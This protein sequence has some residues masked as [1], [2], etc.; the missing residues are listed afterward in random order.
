MREAV[1][2]GVA[3]DGGH[4][5]TGCEASCCA[6]AFADPARGHHIACIGLRS[7]TRG[8][9]L[10]ATPDIKWQLHGLGRPCAGIVLTHAHMGH[11]TGLLQLGREA[12]APQRLPVYAM[13]GMAA[14][15]RA[16]EPYATILAEGHI[17]L[18]PLV[19]D[20]P[21]ELGDGLVLT[22]WQVPHRGP[23]SETV[24]L[25]VQGPDDS[26]LY[27]PDIDAFHPWDRDLADVVA[28]VGRVWIDGTFF[29]AAELPHRD[30]G[31]I[32]HP[33][34]SDTMHRLRALPAELRARVHFLHLNHSN[35]LL[36]E[37]SEA[38]DAV[39]R[40]GFAVARRGDGWRLG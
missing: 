5:Q 25:H 39:R 18:V 27:L 7:A 2:L 29:S 26:C 23:W 9:L 19:A 15:L 30:L 37:G 1:V 13:P 21:V 17:E 6:P 40:A 24:G 4:P 28:Q 34:V 22:P 20:Q 32:P 38:S 3:Q 36:D 8:W 10:D 11:Y 33:L 16:T 35:P 14:F 12:W 31:S